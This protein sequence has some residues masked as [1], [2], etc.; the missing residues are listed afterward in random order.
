MMRHSESGRTW[1]LVTETFKRANCKVVRGKRSERE[2]QNCGLRASKSF[3]KSKAV[4]W[5]PSWKWSCSDDLVVD[6]GALSHSASSF[7]KS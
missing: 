7:R 6:E 1:S 4:T 5:V 3:K 2:V